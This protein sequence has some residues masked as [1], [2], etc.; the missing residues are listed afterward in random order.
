A[1]VLAEMGILIDD[2]RPSF[3]DWL[4]RKLDGIA[5]GIA[6][7]TERWLRA[8]HDG[9]PRIRSR[10]I[11]TVR[12]HLN[13][14]RPVLLAWS[15]R[16]D[17]LREVTREDVLNALDTLHGSQRQ[18]TLISLRSLFRMAKKTGMVFRN[19]TARIRVGERHSTLLQPLQPLLPD[20][21]K[22][23]VTAAVRPA[24]RLI[25]ALATI[26]AARSDGIRR[27]H[28]DDV[29]IGNR[30]L[31]I[32]DRTRPLDELTHRELLNWLDYR[33]SRWPN[34][35]NP[36]LL[37]N[38][39]TALETGPVSAFWLKAAFRGHEAT[40]ERL[41]VDRQLEEA[42]THGA[43]PLHLA[44]VFGLDEKTALRYATAA[45]ALLESPLEHDTVGSPRTH[46]SSPAPGGNPPSGSQ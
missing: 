15:D 11:E 24:D 3:E 35:A 20:Q 17:H 14:A 21:V 10:S 34:T 30:R 8:L 27:L 36:H 39:R 1:G 45:R 19:P 31:T 44:V 5:P 22:K 4:E 2:R 40:L 29:D 7:E 37:I 16:Y 26:H 18:N 13:F 25:I 12:S 42:L 43:D 9:G 33:R 23:T 38:Q 46:G 32:A 6:R 28:L 41:R